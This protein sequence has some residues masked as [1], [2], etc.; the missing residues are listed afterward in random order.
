[1]TAFPLLLVMMLSMSDIE[2]V[3]NSQLPYAELFYQITK[4][5]TV[6]IIIMAWVTLVLFC[7]S[8]LNAGS[9]PSSPN[10]HT[11]NFPLTAALIGQWVTCGRLAWAFARDVDF[12]STFCISTQLNIVF[13]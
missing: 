8:C 1:M 9:T 6:T 7:K 11:S 5:R 13:R 12:S 3:L 2:A 4:N 10:Q